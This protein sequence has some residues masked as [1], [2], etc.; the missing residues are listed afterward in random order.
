MLLTQFVDASHRGRLF[1]LGYR[2]RPDDP[3]AADFTQP[4][5][6]AH[7]DGIGDDSDALHAT[8]AGF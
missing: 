5:F 2:S 7:A 3:R 1:L 8:R 6:G 4:A